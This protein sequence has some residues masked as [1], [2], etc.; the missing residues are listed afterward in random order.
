MGYLLLSVGTAEEAEH[1]KRCIYDIN[2]YGRINSTT[3]DK[4]QK[5]FQ[6]YTITQRKSLIFRFY[7]QNF[8]NKKL[9]KHQMR[10]DIND[11]Y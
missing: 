6:L 9:S 8:P 5:K 4:L 10:A 7:K 11:S 2:S 3:V 1:L